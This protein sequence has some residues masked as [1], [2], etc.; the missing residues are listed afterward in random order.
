[1]NPVNQELSACARK[2]GWIYS[3]LNLVRFIWRNTLRVSALRVLRP[4][5]ALTLFFNSASV[6]AYAVQYEVLSGT[7]PNFFFYCA[8][9]VGCLKQYIDYWNAQNPEHKFS[10]NTCTTPIADDPSHYGQGACYFYDVS[11][12][13]SI[14]PYYLASIIEKPFGPP[15][16]GQCAG[17]P[18]DTATGNKYQ[19]EV[20]ADGR[21]SNLGI[22]RHYN[23]LLNQDVGLGMG[24]TFPFRKRLEI[25]GGSKVNV[26]PGNGH[27]EPFTCYSSVCTGDADT[28]LQ[29]T[30]DATGYTLTHRD[31]SSER[32]NLT[33]KIVSETDSAGRTTSYGYDGSN[34]LSTATDFSGHT[35]TFGYDASNHIATVTDSAGQ[36]VRYSYAVNINTSNN[37]VRVDYPDATA[38]LYHYED[39]NNPQGL[40]GISY[41]DAAGV[42]TRFST[43]DYDA[44]TGKAIRTEHAITD[45]VGPQE[46]FTLTYNSDTQTT[47]TDPVNMQK[48][49]IFATNLGVKNLVTKTS[50]IDTKS[51]QQTFDANNNPTCKKDE[52]N[53]VTLYSYNSTNQRLSM[54]EGLSGTDCNTCLANPA[55]CNVGG[56]GRVTTYEYVSTT[57][58]LPRFIRR[59]SVA[60]GQTF[61]TE[62]Q[63]GD[64]THPNLPTNIIQRGF[65]P[66]G[67][68]V[69]RTV[70]MGYNAYGQVN[71]IDGPRTDVN[72]ITTVEY[73]ECT[74][75]SGCGQLRR[76]VNVL[77]HITAY[78][79]YDANGRLLQMTD[80]NGLVTT[81]S[82][83]PRGRVRFVTQAPP[84]GVS[85]V[86]EYRYDAAGN[87]QQ[88]LLPD[89]IILTYSY[90]AAL[91]L[92]TVSDNLNN[93]IEYS[94]DLK[95]NRTANYTY[96]PSG[97]LTRQ[98][99]MTYDLRNRQATVN[100]AGSLTQTV[101]D[102]VGNPVRETDPNN[103]P[104]TQHTPDALNRLAQTV[105]RLSGVTSYT[106]DYNDRLT[107][108]RSPNGATTGLLY[109]DPG[110]LLQETSPDRGTTIY[111]YDAA[112]N[113]STITDALGIQAI[114]SYNALNRPTLADYPGTTEDITFTHDT[115]TNCG[116]G[117]GRL[118]TVTDQ[119]G[120]TQYGY[121]AFGN[122]TTQQKTELGV[123]YTTSYSY[124]AGNRVTRIVYPDGRAV[125]YTRDAL[126]R[127]A[128]ITT[129]VNGQA[130]TVVTNRGYRPDGLVTAETFGNNL[131]ATRVYDT[132]GQ[133]R[134]LYVGSIDTRL[135]GYDANGNLKSEQAT[136]QVGGYVYDAL[137]RLTQDQLTATTTFGYDANGNRTTENTGVYIY[138]PAS[139]RLSATP[140][141]SVTV[142]SA[143][144]TLSDSSGRSYTYNAAGQI[145]QVTM[146]GTTSSYLYDHRGLRTR[147][148]V[149]MQTTV[150]HYDLV[151]WLLAETRAT[152]QLVRAYVY[153]DTNPLAQIEPVVIPPPD[154]ILDNPQAVFT[155]TWP[156][157]TSLA[158]FYGSNY[159]TNA[160]GSG[161]DKAVWTPTVP[162]A[163]SYQI[164]ARWVAAST[165]A[166][167][168]PYTIKYSTG[169]AAIA[170]NQRLNGG[171]WMLL[172]TYTFN[173]GTTGTI[174]LTDKA[175][176]TVIADAVKLVPTSG[177]TTQEK[178]RY[179]HTDHLNTPRLATDAAQQVL[180]RWDGKAFGDSVPTG[181]ITVNLRYPGQYFDAETGLHYNMARY[182]DPKNGR[183]ISS[184]PI[185]LAGGL[186]TYAYVRN[187]SLRYIDPLGLRDIVAVIWD[188]QITDS[189]V[190]H[191][192][193]AEMNGK[194]IE[195]SFPAPHGMHGVNTTKSWE[196]T[197][198]AEGRTPTAI[199]KVFVPDDNAFDLAATGEKERKWWDWYPNDKDETNCSVASYRALE[200]GKLKLSKPW[201]KPWSP[202]DF[203]DEMNR[204]AARPG[205][206]VTKLPSIPWR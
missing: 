194:I 98:I 17:N 106:Y 49:M 133:L 29:L 140:S 63:Y 157:A 127:I 53:H 91:Y 99:D 4:L 141:G 46:K 143:G 118:C 178:I 172:G 166:S 107:Q 128:G 139:N 147:K 3:V 52:E 18:C 114:Y 162:T 6:S 108:L 94:Y 167:N 135:F 138:L 77:G 13:R 73:N 116:L 81:Y 14:L 101:F 110:N 11:L 8:E 193:L 117:V 195:S 96:D 2:R 203:L 122:I 125:N 132:K 85:R 36:I 28:Q 187:N 159:R 131:N 201:T 1:M 92:R 184:D 150:Y 15:R 87:V 146:A 22:T 136:P 41:V 71:R 80:P 123:T 42:A 23:S 204:L 74:T 144:Q 189:A 75:G 25:I 129:T 130:Q 174:T 158:G 56:V 156:T 111:T 179:L 104:A 90:D 54:T 199:F 115:G 183:Y 58:D 155:G 160:K 16:P 176:G 169:S 37:L 31:K 192:L 164:Y 62:I 126:G 40:T 57:L 86:T 105:D 149:G 51:L 171:Q 198:A 182:Y 100:A 35:L 97:T 168:A 148:T 76:V 83:D 19:V 64:T 191:V 102:A 26:Q 142:N 151:G 170:V 93:R 145:Q 39:A 89:G 88:A 109:D 7:T 38:K 165:N 137:D 205:A 55:T 200:A 173:A 45:N 103:N 69:S 60:A 30:R 175:N 59:P 177:G 24:W 9:P 152:G 48:I 82:Y 61:E 197:V 119:S 33:G 50:S 161:K 153:D 65:T 47:V 154:I 120:T 32:Y 34:R 113:A 44:T 78:D 95:G 180:W 196:E 112:G 202:N 66:T 186:N 20:D 185:G 21:G 181:S 84:A 10:G 163:G 79:S 124:D 27:G 188:R 43:Y 121:D 190:G 12:N 67:A 206:G 68:A 72:D 5:T 134:E 70:T